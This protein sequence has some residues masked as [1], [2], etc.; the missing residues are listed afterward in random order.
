MG[1]SCS[2]TRVAAQDQQADAGARKQARE[3][4]SRRHRAL[5]EELGYDDGGG[6]VRDKADDARYER[7]DDGLVEYYPAQ[8]VLADEVYYRIEREGYN[9]DEERDRE[10]VL[11]RA[12]ENAALFVVAAAVRRFADGVQVDVALA[13]LHRAADEVEEQADD[14]EPFDA[15]MKRLTSELSGLFAKFHDMESAIRANLKSIGFELPAA[16]YR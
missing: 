13:Y 6:A 16:K 9:E 11:E 12:L 1:E 7:P 14:G 4:G 5:E 10:G 15:K 3:H 8:D 2:L